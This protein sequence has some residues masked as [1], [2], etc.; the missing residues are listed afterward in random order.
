MCEECGDTNN[1]MWGWGDLSRVGLRR[2]R[3]VRLGWMFEH[4]CHIDRVH[5][6]RKSI[7]MHKGC[8]GLDARPFG[9]EFRSY[10]CHREHGL[11]EGPVYLQHSGTDERLH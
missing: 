7:F 8:T 6:L 2:W 1:S 5:M 4:M 10:I 11:A 3:G 9:G